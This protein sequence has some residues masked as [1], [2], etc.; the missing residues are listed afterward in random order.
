MS[1]I[2]HVLS[3]VTH[4]IVENGG[5]TSAISHVGK[6]VLANSGDSFK[7]NGVV[8]SSKLSEGFIPFKDTCIRKKVVGNYRSVPRAQKW[9]P[10]GKKGLFES[11]FSEEKTQNCPKRIRK[12]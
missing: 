3:K 8:M 9:V 1:A 4:P 12:F 11:K 2:K 7:Q 10:M 6:M 5:P